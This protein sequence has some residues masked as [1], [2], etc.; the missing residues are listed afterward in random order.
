MS[1]RHQTQ[2]VIGLSKRQILQR[3]K[4]SGLGL[5]WALVNPLVL[6]AVYGYVFSQV[7]KSRW[8]GPGEEEPYALLIFSGLVFFNFFSEILNSSTS[9]VQW[10]SLLI[11]RTTVSSR[12]LPIAQ[13]LASSFT[14]VINFIAL[15]IMY[16][17]LK[18][19]LPSLY[20]LQVVAVILLVAG[21]ATGLGMIIAAVSVY[22]RDLQQIVPLLTTS[23]LFFSPVFYPLKDLPDHLEPIVNKINPLAFPLEQSKRA[24]FLEEW[25]DWTMVGFYALCV[26]L[27][28]TLANLIYK[29]AS[30]GFADVI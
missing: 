25:L 6:L 12:I 2:L 29:I 26:I 28:L 30:R 22:L 27:L 5:A 16:L 14:L 18:G 11:K 24:L 23:L 17:V 19:S 21:V 8:S 4:E 15:L 10:N 9:L 13:T 3:Y 20:S 1:F 7:F